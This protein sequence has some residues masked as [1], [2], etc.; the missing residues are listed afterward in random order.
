MWEALVG[1]VL[2]DEA[3]LVYL[4]GGKNEGTLFVDRQ[5]TICVTYSASISVVWVQTESAMRSSPGE[6]SFLLCRTVPFRTKSACAIPRL[7]SSSS[8]RSALAM[9]A[10]CSRGRNQP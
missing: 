10:L 3:V 1:N 4:L 9:K 7:I 5:D 2:G 8:V 6:L